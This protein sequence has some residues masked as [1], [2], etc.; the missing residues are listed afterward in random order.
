MRWHLVSSLAHV[1]LGDALRVDRQPLVRVDHHA[2][3]ARVGLKRCG[4]IDSLLGSYLVWSSKTD[5]DLWKAGNKFLR[6]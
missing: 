2:E 3:Q 4:L 5:Q 6:R 1:E